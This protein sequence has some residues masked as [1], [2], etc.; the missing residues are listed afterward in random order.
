M[1]R[2][3]AAAEPCKVRALVD[4]ELD[5]LP[6]VSTSEEAEIEPLAPVILPL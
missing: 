6:N 1:S 3:P 5:I 2:F 4:I